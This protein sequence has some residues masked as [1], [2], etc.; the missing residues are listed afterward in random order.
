MKKLTKKDISQK[1]IDLFLEKGYNNVTINDICQACDI[2]KPTFYKYAG[3]K[4][5][6]ILDL[7]DLSINDLTKDPY[8]FIEASSH[9][10]QL[11]MVFHKLM[12]DTESFGSDLFSQMLISNLTEDHHSFDMRAE[13][14]R[15]CTLIIKKAQEK[16]E[17]KNMNPPEI[18]Y[19][20][21]AY[22]FTGYEVSWC[23][24]KG[25]LDFRGELYNSIIAILD[26]KEELR[27]VHKKYL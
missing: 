23:I 9:Y 5:D 27:E 7:Y 22:T 20:T 6:L 1:A 10:E 2:T 17:I 24:K 14:T 26:V 11:I 15:I 25:E 4:E 8:Y 13:L 19:N 18:L 3:S 21:I 12:A 16:G